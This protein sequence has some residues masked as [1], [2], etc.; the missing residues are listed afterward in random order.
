MIRIAMLSKWHVHAAGYAA[1]I[2]KTDD[3]CITCVWDDDNT[4]GQA[5]ADELGVAFEADLDTLL[6][7][8]DVDAVVVGTPTT[9][10]VKVMVAAA[11]AG[12]HIFTEKAMATTLAGCREIS[13]AIARNNVKFCIS[14]PNLTTSI[15]QLA[16]QVIDDGLLGRVHYLRMR[17]AHA[18]SLLGWL[19]DYWYDVEKSGG[20]AMMD[21]GCHPM[22][23]AS[24][25]LG[26]P[27]RIASVFNTS[28]A[29]PPNDDHSVSVVAFADQAI[30]V[31]ETSFISPWSANCFELLGT[32][33]ALVSV[34]GQ[35]K[36]RSKQYPVEGW[37]IPD[38]L[39]D[40]LPMALRQWLDGI[41]KGTP[42]P[43]DT[44][45]GEALTELLENAYRSHE[46]QTIVRI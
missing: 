32:E 39:P 41:S 34:D 23:T 29:P 38:K 14:L 36:I 15:V 11:N 28:Y 9:D 4:R 19:P 42:I 22:Y 26:K 17:N 33:G 45:R 12:K 30:A 27:Q 37:V 25:L 13:S 46:Q 5:W 7:R 44:E 43:F 2:R 18:G 35:V 8:S 24:Y 3:A 40:P 1:Q 20:G 31:L 6:A 10:H 16:R 21:L